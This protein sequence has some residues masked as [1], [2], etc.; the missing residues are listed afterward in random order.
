MSFQL[1]IASRELVVVRWAT[2][3]ENQNMVR[4]MA[5]EPSAACVASSTAIPILVLSA[6]TRR[7]RDQPSYHS[8]THNSDNLLSPAD[9]GTHFFRI[10]QPMSKLYQL[11]RGIIAFFT[12]GRDEHVQ[13][14][15]LLIHL[16]RGN[17]RK[18]GR[19][20]PLQD[21]PPCCA[22]TTCFTRYSEMR[23]FVPDGPGST[24]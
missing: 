3:T 10:G 15:N 17:D 24:F 1:L 20:P 14:M 22:V 13:R 18:C 6:K 23:S 21:V 9:H 12:S 8:T 7:T 2:M 16:I 19:F 11:D 5:K 4:P